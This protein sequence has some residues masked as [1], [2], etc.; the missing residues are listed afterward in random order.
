MNICCKVDPDEVN[1][2][3]QLMTWKTTVADISY[4]GAKGGIGCNPLDLT[5]SEL[6]R[7]TRAFTQKI[8]DLRRI[9][10]D[11]PAPDVGT[12]AQRMAW[13]LDEYSKFHGHSP[14]VVTGKSID[15]RGSVGREATTRLGVVF[16]TEA[17]LA[18][19]G[20]SIS[21][22]KFAIQGFGN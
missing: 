4:S 17:L 8:H 22:M 11:V 12:N 15:L 13:I 10:A 9:H 5:K 1:A 6:E 18:D 14:T 20:E 21:K 7:L 19:Y 3:A 16:A 2:L